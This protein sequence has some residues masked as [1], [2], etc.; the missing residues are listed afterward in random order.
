MGTREVATPHIALSEWI[1]RVKRQEAV[2]EM[3]HLEKELK[4]SDPLI[5][6]DAMEALH[7]LAIWLKRHNLDEEGR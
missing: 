5:A 2:Q 6:R 3:V 1:R 7:E 4:S